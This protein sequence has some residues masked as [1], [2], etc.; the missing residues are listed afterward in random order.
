M[1]VDRQIFETIQDHTRERHRN[2]ELYSRM[3]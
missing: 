1:K 2:A 3:Q